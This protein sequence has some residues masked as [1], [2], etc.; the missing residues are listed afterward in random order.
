MLSELSF[1][2][3]AI[4]M[5]SLQSSLNH[6]FPGCF[7]ICRGIWYSL[8]N[9]WNYCLI[10]QQYWISSIS[11]HFRLKFFP[12][13]LF[14]QGPVSF[15]K[16]ISC[17]SFTYSKYVSVPSL[18]IHNPSWEIKSSSFLPLS[19][20]VL[21]PHKGICPLKSPMMMNGVGNWSAKCLSWVKLSHEF[22]ALL[23][24]CDRLRFWALG[25]CFFFI[26]TRRII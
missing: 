14:V 21:L 20:V 24:R 1:G 10:K 26:L 6:G 3:F 13:H 12:A 19:E 5:A 11:D 7:W 25:F 17:R 23:C 8:I 9:Y 15:V 18:K 16:F 2:L 22:S 4:L